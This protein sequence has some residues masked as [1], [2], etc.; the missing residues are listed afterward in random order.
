MNSTQIESLL[1]WLLG[2]S[3]PI[4]A[5]L[6][7]WGI[8]PDNLGHLLEIVIAAVAVIPPLFALYLSIRAHTRSREIAAVEAIPE[9]EKILIK[10][11]ATGTVAAVA[12]DPARPKVTVR[13]TSMVR[14]KEV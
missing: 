2:T 8:T 12:A 14:S 1:R 5:L 9:V 13:L 11:T 4:G 6:I 7:Y 10:P 3:G